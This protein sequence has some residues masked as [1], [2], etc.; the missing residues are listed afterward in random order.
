MRRITAIGFVCFFVFITN[1]SI[2]AQS[3]EDFQVTLTNDNKGVVIVKYKGTARDVHIPTTIQGLPVREIG[4]QAFMGEILGFSRVDKKITSIIIPE[5][6]TKIGG[7]AFNESNSLISVVLPTTL[8]EI[9]DFAFA[10]LP[11][12]SSIKLPA[13]LKIIGDNAFYRCKSLKSIELPSGLT[14]IGSGAFKESG[15]SLFPN[16]W[17][18]GVTSIAEG[19]FEDTNITDFAVPEGIKIIYSNAFSGC[20]NLKNI[21][22]PS[23]IE[24]F[25]TNAFANSSL[26]SIEIPESVT[27]L[28][29]GYGAFQYLRNLNLASQARLRALNYTGN[30]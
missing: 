6:V 22:I 18:V 8:I 23:S 17:P 1:V 21:T 2:W 16:P 11:L 19:M 9:G 3:E 24:G 13:G 5:G 15:L 4:Y 28:K 12:F 10:N 26:I 25:D 20:R 27:K 14:K 7:S 30:F 29:Y